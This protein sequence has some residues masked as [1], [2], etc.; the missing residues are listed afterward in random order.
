MIIVTNGVII[1]S[2]LVFPEIS[3]PISAAITAHQ[4]IGLMEKISPIKLYTKVKKSI[5]K[6][7]NIRYNLIDEN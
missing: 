3:L 7:T 6:N 5:E 2:I 1:I 4:K